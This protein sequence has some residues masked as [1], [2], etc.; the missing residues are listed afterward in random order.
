MN[1]FY[2]IANPTTNNGLWYD[3]QGGFTGLIHGRY[4]FCAA[5]ELYMPFD[6]EL[7][8]FLS[9]ADSL[10][11]LLTWFPM[12]DIQRLQA[13]GYRVQVYEAADFK[14]YAPFQHNVINQQTSRL[15]STIAL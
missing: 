7:T 15:V 4:D 9:A 12:A 3:M 2:R 5:S 11:H 14:H 13:E 1:T 8:G 10:E 6:P